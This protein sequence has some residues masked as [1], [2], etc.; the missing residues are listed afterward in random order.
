[1]IRQ[2]PGKGVFFQDIRQSGLVGKKQGQI[3]GK[4]AM[5]DVAQNL[6]IFIMVQ[7]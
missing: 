1:M 3:R 4:N 2:V 6:P 5:L 7:L